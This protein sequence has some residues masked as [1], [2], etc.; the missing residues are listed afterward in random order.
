MYDNK[1]SVVRTLNDELRNLRDGYTPE[2]INSR[3]RES[4]NKYHVE[5]RESKQKVKSTL[6]G[7]TPEV[8]LVVSSLIWTPRAQLVAGTNRNLLF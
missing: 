8:S 6:R 1:G 3:P 2:T 4:A 5:Y 7:I